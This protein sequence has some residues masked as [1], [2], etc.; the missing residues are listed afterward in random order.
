MNRPLFVAAFVACAFLVMNGCGNS[1]NGESRGDGSAQSSGD[2]AACGDPSLSALNP[3]A[4]IDDMES[5]DSAT[6]MGAARGAG[7]WA[8][9]DDPSKAAG[10]SITPDGLVTAEKIPG[11]RC[12]STYANHVTGQGFGTW[13]IMNVS[14]GWGSVD[15]GEAAQLPYDASFR[16][17]ITFWAR[18]GDTSSAN[19]RVNISDKYSNDAGGICDKSIPSG[20]TACYDHFGVPLNDLSTTW[21]QYKV[22]FRGLAQE[23]FGIPR[24]AL[25]TSSLYDVA[26]SLPRG[27]TFDL[28]VDDISFY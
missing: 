24:E 11:G 27:T 15:G 8:G 19:V 4:L 5:P 28:W 20:S 22:P 10:A 17:G 6:A 1:S 7:W 25:D 12:G 13:A 23:G 14:F 21:H 16:S 3:T 2:A 26:F 18:V 9:G